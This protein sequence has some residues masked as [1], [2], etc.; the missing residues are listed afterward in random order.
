[1]TSRVAVACACVLVGLGAIVGVAS[2]A[3]P[4]D[5]YRVFHAHDIRV[6]LPISFETTTFGAPGVLADLAGPHRER[7]TLTTKRARDRSLAA[8]EL[9]ALRQM[10]RVTP[11][12]VNLRREDVDVPGADEARRITFRDVAHEVDV[13]TIIA[14][15]GDRYVTLS[16]EMPYGAGDEVLDADSVEDSFAITG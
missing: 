4:P 16:I 1:M 15:D 8:Q 12:V 14:R 6:D 13:T 7:I 3:G 2:T 11:E 9:L 5:G 10:R